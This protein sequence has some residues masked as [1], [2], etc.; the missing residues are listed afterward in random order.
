MV[1]LVGCLQKTALPMLVFAE[2]KANMD[3]IHKYLLLKGMEAV[4]T[5]GGRDQEECNKAIETFH[6]GEEGRPAAMEIDSKGLDFPTIPHVIKYIP[7][8]IEN[9][10]HHISCMGHSGNKGIATTFINKSY[11]KLLLMN[12]KTLVLEPRGC[13]PCCK[14]FTVNPCWILA[15]SSTM[16]SVE[17]SVTGS[18][19]VP[20][21]RPGRPSR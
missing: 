3:S 16:I 4:A 18:L 14:G 8:E 5:H 7:K 12:F 11:D 20:S 9:Y 19:T 15:K 21:W 10:V 6:I 17:A 13:H 1:C 2:K